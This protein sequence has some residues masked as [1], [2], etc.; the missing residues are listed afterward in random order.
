MVRHRAFY[1]GDDRLPLPLPRATEEVRDVLTAHPEYTDWKESYEVN[2]D[3]GADL[4][5][6][7]SVRPDELKKDGQPSHA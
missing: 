4:S 6:R 5:V 3:E 2:V 7:A 1:H